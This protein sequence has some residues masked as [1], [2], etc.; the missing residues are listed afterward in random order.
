MSQK[1]Q[2]NL[3]KKILLQWIKNFPWMIATMEEAQKPVAKV[4]DNSFNGGENSNVWF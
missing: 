1:G 3:M 2:I 4:D